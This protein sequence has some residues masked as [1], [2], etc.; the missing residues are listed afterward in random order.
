MFQGGDRVSKTQCGAFDSYPGCH[1]Q[2][3][4]YIYLL[5]APINNNVVIFPDQRY[6]DKDRIGFI[7]QVI[8][9]KSMTHAWEF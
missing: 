5:Q 8:P 6:N 2:K 1:F 7:G 4:R 9:I 3:F